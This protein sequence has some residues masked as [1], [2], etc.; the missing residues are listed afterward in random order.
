MEHE[1]MNESMLLICK[2]LGIEPNEEMNSEQQI[3]NTIANRV[4]HLLDRDIDLLLS[5]LYRLDVLEVNINAALKTGTLGPPDIALAKLIL[6]RQ[7]KRI[8]TKKK[9]KV[10][11]IEGWEF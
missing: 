9:Y 7:I 11:P 8:E 3:L 10:D 6:D 5:Y 1:H 2:D 4:A